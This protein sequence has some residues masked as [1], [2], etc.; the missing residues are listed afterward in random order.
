MRGEQ[1]ALE[2][3]FSR[4]VAI[5]APFAA[6]RGPGIRGGYSL[7]KNCVGG[8]RNLRIDQRG[9]TA[10]GVVVESRGR[11]L[12]LTPSMQLVDFLD[13]LQLALGEL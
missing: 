10:L 7:G 1:A 2:S 12:P 6:T 8:G 13:H 5:R 11:G 3:G 4:L 9:V